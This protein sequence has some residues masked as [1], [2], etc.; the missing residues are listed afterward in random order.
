MS[1]A[2]PDNV[3]ALRCTLDYADLD[4][5]VAHY[6]RNVSTRGVF[7]PAQEPPSVGTAVRFEV[8]LA[9][10]QLALHGEGVV[11]WQAPLDASHKDQLHGMA[12]RFLRLDAPSRSVIERIVAY[13]AAHPAAFF[14]TTPDPLTSPRDTASLAP[15]AAPPEAAGTLPR[16]AAPVAPVAP[17]V[18]DIAPVAPAR[19][20]QLAKLPGQAGPEDAELLALATPPPLQA[21]QASEAGR[22]LDALLKRRS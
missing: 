3:L 11:V 10:G 4:A 14:E 1:Q 9:S 13:K 21:V 7:L 6:G 22:R 18:P 20:Q 19:A 16:G 17:A 5:F 2:A 12:V 8:M 15:L